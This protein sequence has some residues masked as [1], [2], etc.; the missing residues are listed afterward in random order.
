MRVE[1]PLLTAE[2]AAVHGLT[3]GGTLSLVRPPAPGEPSVGG[4]G[5]RL[6][7]DGTA[8]LLD[9]D[10][11]LPSGELSARASG[12]DV[13]VGTL[14]DSMIDLG[15]TTRG[16]LDTARFTDGGVARLASDTGSVI[17]GAGGTSM[18]PP[19]RGAATP[20]PSM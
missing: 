16:F 10:I 19:P 17:I 11:V 1:S 3:A 13:R 4:L 20:E 14:D 8:V 6:N 12:G 18:S 7:L 15:G 5:A 9:T 2:Q